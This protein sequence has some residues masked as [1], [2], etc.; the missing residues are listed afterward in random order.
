MNQPYK[1]IFPKLLA[2]IK[3]LEMSSVPQQLIFYYEVVGNR[4]LRSSSTFLPISFMKVQ[5]RGWMQIAIF[6][7]QVPFCRSSEFERQTN[8]IDLSQ[9]F[10]KPSTKTSC[11]VAKSFY[12]LGMI[13]SVG[14]HQRRRHRRRRRRTSIL[15]DRRVDVNQQNLRRRAAAVRRESNKT[16]MS[17]FFPGH[18]DV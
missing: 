6:E 12:R 13:G 11:K 18:R 15:V 5:I 3:Q 2:R 14:E 4:P 17:S 10:L 16:S 1:S 9:S 7:S 8:N